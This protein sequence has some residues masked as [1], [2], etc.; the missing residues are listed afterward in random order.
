MAL[1]PDPREELP[2]RFD[3]KMPEEPKTRKTNC[4]VTEEKDKNIFKIIMFWFFFAIFGIAVAAFFGVFSKIEI[5]DRYYLLQDVGWERSQSVL[6]GIEITDVNYA[7][8]RVRY[9]YIN[10]DAV[11]EKEMAFSALK[12]SYVP[13]D[14]VEINHSMEKTK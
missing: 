10:L 11:D 7:A 9:K 13:A 3:F 1:A 4:K 8:E 5:G 12:R 14:S 2:E 6:F